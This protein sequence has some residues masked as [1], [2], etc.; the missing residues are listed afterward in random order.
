MAS[1][2]CEFGENPGILKLYLDG[3]MVDGPVS[4]PGNGTVSSH[5]EV[6]AVGAPQGTLTL[7]DFGNFNGLVDDL[8]VY[9]RGLSGNEIN[10][11]FLEM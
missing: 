6:P 1:L 10:Q 8:R 7:E 2:R 11:L 9:D 5:D 4:T 3:Q